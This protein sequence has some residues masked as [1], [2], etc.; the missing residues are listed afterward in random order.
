MI[1]PILIAAIAV[2]SCAAGPKPMSFAEHTLDKA[3]KNIIV[4]VADGWSYNCV[5]AAGYFQ[6]GEKG[7][8]P[9]ERDFTLFPMSTFSLNGQ[10]YDPELAWSDYEYLKKGAADS[11]AT[12]TTMSTGVKTTN[13][14]IGVDKDKAPLEH[15]VQVAE[16]TGKA[17]GVVT[18]VQMSHA[19]PAAFVAHVKGRGAYAD[20]AKEMLLES[21]C[22]VI[23]GAGHPWYDNDGKLVLT[24]DA[25]GVETTPNSYRFVGDEALWRE[26]VAG[27]AGGDCDG[28]GQPDAWKLIQTREEF[29]QL[30][31][32]D[33][34]KRVLGVPQVADALQVSR[35]SVDGVP[36]DDAAFQTPLLTTVPTLPEM[37]LAA[38]N[39]L[40][41]D[42]DG[43]YLMIEG[44]AVDWANHANVAGRMIEEMIGYGET[45]QAVSDWVE[46]NSSWDET[47]VIVTG[48]HECGYLLGPGSKPDLKPIVNNGKGVMPGMEYH[49][50]SHTNQLIPCYVRGA[51][52]ELFTKAA[53]GKDPVRGAYID[54]T[55]VG[56]ITKR[57][58][59]AR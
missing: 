57:L 37:A 16:K 48:D 5:E 22:E 26:C 2:N 42:P 51:G 24:K 23:M 19:T 32:G 15:A 58:L 1:F 36:E 7:T 6:H 27:A 41:N 59:A 11:A 38:L 34:P 31:N 44:G 46:K 18:S 9:Y 8:Q 14:A 33:T 20:I 21:G 43:F 12:A 52:V 49:Y 10:G 54:N 55:D 40:D 3:P 28:D 35:T 17:T 29:Q 50:K 39:V 53:T 47:L 13:G 45:V 25:N 56:L 30:A 4:L